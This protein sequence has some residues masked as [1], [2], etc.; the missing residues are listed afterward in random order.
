MFNSIQLKLVI[1]FVLVVL[2]VVI[3]VGTFFLYSMSDFYND[4]FYSNMHQ[5]FGSDFAKQLQSAA[6]SPSRDEGLERLKKLIEVYSGRLGVDSYRSCFILNASDSSFVYSKDGQNVAKIEITPNII[7]AMNGKESKNAT[8]GTSFMDY[9]YPI[10]V[11]NNSNYIIYIKDTKEE[12][13]EIMRKIISIIMQ[14]LLVGLVLSVGLGFFIS[15]TITAPII[16]LTKKAQNM[17]AGDFESRIQVRS[18]DEIGKLTTTF[19]HMAAELKETLNAIASEKNKVETILLYMTDG[20]MAFDSEGLSIHIN[21]AAKRMLG[22]NEGQTINFD[23]YF[24]ALNA[25][26]TMSELFFKSNDTLERTIEVGEKNIMAYFAAFNIEEEKIGGVVVALHDITE[27][28][29]L[30]RARREFVANV[31]HELRTPLTTIKSYTETILDSEQMPAE[32]SNEFLKVVVSEADR[33]TRLVKDLLILT[34]LDN[35]KVAIKREEF[36]IRQ[37]LVEVVQKLN[38]EAKSYDHSLS[39]SETTAL[40]F[41]KGDRDRIEQVLINIISNAIKYTHPGGKIEVFAGAVYDHIYIK[42]RD[43]GI[44]IPTEDVKRIFERF[45][46]VD[47]ARSRDSGGTGLGLAIAK[48]IIEAHNGSITI[49]S[50]QDIGTEVTIKLPI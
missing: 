14:A 39:F 5:V 17:A 20:V 33:M 34:R 28:Q 49:S 37:L 41:Y 35:D 29:K 15:R 4:E 3:V 40:P 50:K 22:L 13:M 8:T 11:G 45:Y 30:E 10:I 1:M 16:S 47:K 27:Q 32:T 46:R 21:R 19:N 31:S 6:A 9:A 24:T 2:S 42:I 26:I 12:L 25:D 38:L 7:A 18:K 36:S 23:Q 44:G 48:E 43:N